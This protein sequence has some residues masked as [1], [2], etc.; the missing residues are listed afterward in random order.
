MNPID[1]HTHSY[2]SDGT[3]SPAALVDLAKACGLRAL[4]LTDHDTTAGLKEGEEAAAQA[5]LEFVPG[6]ELAADYQHTELHFLGLFIQ[7]DNPSLQRALQEIAT[8]RAERNVKMLQRLSENGLPIQKATWLLNN[9]GRIL[10]RAHFAQALVE[11]GYCQTPREAFSKYLSSEGPIFIPRKRLAAQKAI[12][13]IHYAGGLVFLAHPFLYP[14]SRE[15][16]PHAVKDLQAMGLDGI[17]SL[18]GTNT[19][20][21][22]IFLSGLAHKCRLLTTGGSDFHGTNKT[23][24]QLGVGT[25]RLFVPY[26]VLEAMKQRL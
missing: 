23:H 25:G 2:Y 18:Y 16:V 5:G 21:D 19:L 1:L 24:I 12:E 11:E 9:E 22:D 3:L 14:L 13:L 8:D 10:T 20:A 26:T 4:A 6:I 15:Q 17:E 7:K